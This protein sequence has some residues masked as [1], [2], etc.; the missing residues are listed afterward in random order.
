MPP[1]QT[2]WLAPHPDVIA[3][4]GCEVRILA[5]TGR[6]SMAHFSLGPGQIARAVVHR[7]VEEIWY[8]LEGEGRMWRCLD[9][10]EEIT[11]VRPGV[12]LTIPTG[13]RFQLRNDGATPVA[14]VAITMPPWP[15]EQEAVIV[16]G[17]W[18]ARLT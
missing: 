11:P 3:P 6:G 17:R 4:D 18:P 13:V 15:G 1:W 2:R 9:D 10:D 12:S 14:A 16:E 7:T 5:Q 8:F